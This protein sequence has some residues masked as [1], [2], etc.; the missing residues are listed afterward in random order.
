ME[1]EEVEAASKT[2]TLCQEIGSEEK[3]SSTIVV[4]DGAGVRIHFWQW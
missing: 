4:W 1:N 3:E 2:W